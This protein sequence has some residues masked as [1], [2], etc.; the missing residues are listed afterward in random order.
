MPTLANLAV[1]ITGDVS[2]LKKSLDEADSLVGGFA[3]NAVKSVQ[4]LGRV[5]L[6]G[7]V[8]G[9]GS[10][11]AGIGLAFKT[12]VPMAR[13]FEDSLIKLKLASSDAGY[14]FDELREAALAVGGDTRLLGV[15]ASGASESMT[16]LYK[17]GLTTTEIFG[18]MQGYM[19][20]AAELGGALRASIDLAAASELDMVQASDLATIAMSTFGGELETEAER[21]E[22]ATAA[23][24]N[25]VKAADASV[26]EVSDLA[27]ALA[28]VGPAANDMG[29]SIEETNN[30]LAVLST[31][32][33]TGSRA[34]TTLEAVFRDLGKRQTA[35]RQLGVELY[36]VGEETRA[37]GDILADLEKG[38]AGMTDEQR[39][40]ALSSIGL[41]NAQRGLKALLAEGSE[42]WDTMARN[43]AAATGIQAQAESRAK[44]L[45][46]AWE[47]FVGNLETYAIK[48]GSSVLPAAKSLVSIGDMIAEM[49]GPKVVE[50][51]QQV[52][53]I[54]G[55]VMEFIEAFV[56]L[57][58]DGED[59]MTAFRAAAM[60]ILPRDM[61]SKMIEV[62]DGISEFI[63]QI[64]EAAGPIL[65]WIS[66]N[67]EMRDVLMTLGIAISSVIL[68]ALLG[69]ITWLAPLV[70]TFFALIAVVKL[71]RAAW[72]DLAAAW[73]ALK[74]GDFDAFVQSIGNAFSSMWEVVQPHLAAFWGHIV[75]WV[76]SVDWAQIGSTIVRFI[77]G[78]I[79]F[80]QELIQPKIDALFGN[81]TAWFL[82][83]EWS[84]IGKD[85]A[86]W[87]LNGF[88]V[89][90][91]F[92]AE[93]ALEMQQNLRAWFENQDWEQIGYDVVTA[94]IKGIFALMVISA[95]VNAQI[96]GFLEEVKSQFLGLD[97]KQLGID[98]LKGIAQGL[99]D[100]SII[101]DALADVASGALAAAK[102]LFKSRSPSHLFANEIGVT[103][104]RGIAM[105]IN[106]ATVDALDAV[107]N[108]SLD[109]A[110]A[111]RSTTSN[112]FGPLTVQ[113]NSAEEA[114]QVID[115]YRFKKAWGG[116]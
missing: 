37:F 25:M 16:N 69:F 95:K 115:D 2:G 78:G 110:K 75:A 90:Q 92:G 116:T 9:V 27:E 93:K 39:D 114:N 33:I 81:I 70:I 31:R 48:I 82:G 108:M 38:L 47:G 113:V 63:E 51:F 21:S 86:K 103:I 29:L 19:D 3:G 36:T 106:N 4:S 101:K 43:T 24:N 57:T 11:A 5:A 102:D 77:S 79:E 66:D 73:E 13:E 10:A 76:A 17:A 60:K 34:G 91:E 87:I 35:L 28:Y 58:K 20:G 44:S 1:K 42:G 22:F 104:P 50:G 49:W 55:D 89:G 61:W 45:S 40:A 64:Q 6:G 30:A 41:T 100:M 65:D 68:P 26:A 109:V 7:L 80:L 8:A 71:V 54:I 98:I 99:A 62:T 88:S 94:I 53:D 18:D 46:G 83:I 84:T 23:M 74:A 12:T 107:K 105:G 32:G 72:D 52:G 15:S 67:A 56:G 85:L 97:W 111:G 96:S 14:S 59:P 112:E